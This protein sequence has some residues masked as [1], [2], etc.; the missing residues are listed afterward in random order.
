[1]MGKDKRDLIILVLILGLGFMLL[2]GSLQH[3]YLN[4]KF[5]KDF[6]NKFNS[7]QA[8]YN[9]GT[10]RDISQMIVECIPD[11]VEVFNLISLNQ[12]HK[13]IMFK[14]L[15]DN[16]TKTMEFTSLYRHKELQ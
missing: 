12:K 14:C 9:D 16:K 5:T 7:F 15:K 4:K 1:M 3:A 13:G 8:G 6:N 10:I 2:F 11:N